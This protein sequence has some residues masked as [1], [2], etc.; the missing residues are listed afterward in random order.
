MLKFGGLGAGGMTGGL[1]MSD[2]PDSSPCDGDCAG[3]LAL[4]SSSNINESSSCPN[5]RDPS[6]NRN[7]G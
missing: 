7:N 6:K 5:G 1:P 2:S 4:L 3:S